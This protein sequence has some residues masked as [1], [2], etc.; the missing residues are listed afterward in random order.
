MYQLDA[1]AY[2][3]RYLAAIISLLFML[4]CGLFLALAVP[5]TDFGFHW[6]PEDQLVILE[7]PETSLA[8]GLLQPGDVVL[9][10]DGRPV[11]R[12]AV[13]FAPPLK[14]AY[15][16][17]LQRG[18]NTFTVTVP[19]P[20]ALADIGL[21]YRLPTG[22]LAGGFWLVAF[23]ML[24]F[25]R[26]DNPTAVQVVYIFLGLAVSLAGVQAEILSVTGAWLSRPFWFVSV[27]GIAYLGFV[28]RFSPLPASVRHLFGWL[29]AIAAGLGLAAFVEAAWLFP[30]HTSVDR[31][32]GIGLYEAMLAAGGL[33]WLVCFLILVWRAWRMPAITYERRQLQILLVFIGLAILPVTLLT[34]LPRGLFDVVFLPFPLA[35]VLFLLVPAGYLFVI[36]RRG[37]LGLDVVFSKTAVF[38]ILALVTLVV[39]GS[40]LAVIRLYRP[41]A[42]ATI[43]LDTLV[44][45]PTLVLALTMSQPVKRQ[46]EGLFFGEVIRNQSLPHFA[47]ALSLKPE[48]ETLEAIVV[49]LAEDFH[50][51][52]AVLVLSGEDGRLAVV[53]Q[54]NGAAIPSAALGPLRRFWQPVLRSAAS[55]DP[56]HILFETLDWAELLLPIAVREK[57]VGY[58]ALARPQDGYFNAEQ[59]AFLTRAADMIA[60]GSEAIYLFD[61]ARQFSL[62]VASAHEQERKSLSKQIHDQP[63]QTIT[64]VTHKLQQMLSSSHMV[65]HDIRDC[66]EQQ[67]ALLQSAMDELR[68]LSMGLFPPVL[69]QGLELVVADVVDRFERQFALKIEQTVEIPAAVRWQ[70]SV[71]VATA[72]YRVLTEALNNVVK[73][74]QTNH[75]WLTLTNTPDALRLEVADDGV[76]CQYMTLSVPEL[77]RRQ[78]LGLVGMFEWADM[79]QGK[80]SIIHRQPRGTAVILEI[81]LETS[82]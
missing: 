40:A 31:L 79:T 61:A 80:L 59:V 27:V 69:E 3:G 38:L 41:E 55:G 6:R 49:Q 34:L 16:F 60:V 39:Y 44:F 62:K 71:E 63:L 78:H 57:Q 68:T 36:Y 23:I 54:I 17:T 10:V 24:R 77:V 72:V 29:W 82:P 19:M 9:A 50:V 52:Q 25:A 28:P 56:H 26:R 65:N 12:T 73:H 74:A 42:S 1:L 22:L 32:L 13:L 4:Y 5:I 2:R 21:S 8:Q 67:V 81:P 46:I 58:L 11:H 53:A 51:R 45:L 76:G 15:Q 70:A 14:D 75:A 35:I 37:Y 43:M 66:L 30:Q 7:V 18:E 64:Y 47:T 48:L 20:D 33:A